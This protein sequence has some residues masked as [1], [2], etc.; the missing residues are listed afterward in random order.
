[1]KTLQN[2]S[3]M[4]SDMQQAKSI[5]VSNNDYSAFYPSRDIPSDL[6]Q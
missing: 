2:M 3:N 5:C 1:M 4:H 6:S